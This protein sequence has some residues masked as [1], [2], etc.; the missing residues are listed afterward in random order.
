MKNRYERMN[1]SEWALFEEGRK[2]SKSPRFVKNAV[3]LMAKYGTYPRTPAMLP[4]EISKRMTSYYGRCCYGKW[5]KI[6]HYHWKGSPRNRVIRTLRHEYLHEWIRYN[7]RRIKDQVSLRQFEKEAYYTFGFQGDHKSYKY[8]YTGNKC[9][10][11]RKTNNLMKEWICGHGHVY[12]KPS[13]YKEAKANGGTY[14]SRHKRTDVPVSELGIFRKKIL[15]KVSN[16]GNQ[17]PTL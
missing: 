15:I 6:A 2:W 7:H 11:W 9:R 4:V 3:K 14:R 17:A 1:R 16:G 13:I 10:C 8:R 12:V 5:I